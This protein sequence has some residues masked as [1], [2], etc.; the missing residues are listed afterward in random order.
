MLFHLGQ[1]KWWHISNVMWHYI[2]HYTNNFSN[3]I[4]GKISCKTSIHIHTDKQAHSIC[5]SHHHSYHTGL[6]IHT[7]TAKRK[8]RQKQYQY[9]SWPK[10]VKHN[11]ERDHA[12]SKLEMQAE[13]LCSTVASLLAKWKAGKINRKGSKDGNS[14][15]IPG[16]YSCLVSKE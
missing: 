5:L 9:I 14:T 15:T 4:S 12:Q 7:H 1:K 8:K 13:V 10:F 2:T 11:T 3:D 6:H 16:S